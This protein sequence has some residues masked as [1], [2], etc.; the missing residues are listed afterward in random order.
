MTGI[1]TALFNIY[2]WLTNLGFKFLDVF[3]PFLRKLIFKIVLG[4]FGKKSVIDYECYIRYPSRVFIGEKVSINRGCSLF[5]SFYNKD[6]RITIGNNV[7]VGPQVTFFSAGHDYT[8]LDL[9][10]IASSITVADNVWIGGRSVIL[11]GVTIGEGAV[12]GAGSVVTKDVAPYTI[13]IGV[14]A[15]RIKDREI[16]G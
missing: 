8:R 11:P 15:A 14:P 3:P 5:P 6:V 1:M 10:D 4:K 2:S 12:V 9:P 16:N 7:A 13:V